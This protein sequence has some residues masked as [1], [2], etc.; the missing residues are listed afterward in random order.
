MVEFLIDVVELL[1]DVAVIGFQVPR[2][3]KSGDLHGEAQVHELVEELSALEHSKHVRGAHIQVVIRWHIS[4][5]ADP[6][7][8]LSQGEFLTANTDY[9]FGNFHA[10]P[11]QGS[12]L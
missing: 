6:A 5:D 3:R 4:E 10:P 11:F 2:A 12:S 7:V 8:E 9:Q 1:C